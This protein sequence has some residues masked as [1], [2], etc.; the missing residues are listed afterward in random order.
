MG[1]ISSPSDRPTKLITIKLVNL[2][3]LSNLLQG[4]K[5]WRELSLTFDTPINLTIT[6][7]QSQVNL[8]LEVKATNNVTIDGLISG[9][10]SWL[11]QG[12]L[13]YSQLRLGIRVDI[14]HPS[15]L[16]GLEQW[17][18]LNLLSDIQVKQLCGQHLTSTL[19]PVATPKVSR[20]TRQQ[21]SK[22]KVKPRQRQRSLPKIAQMLQGLMAELSVIWLLLLGV[23]MVVISSGVLAASQWEKFPAIAQY[24]ILWVYTLGFGGASW[25]TSHKP[26]LR[27]TTQA[28]RVVTLS[29]VPINFVALDSFALWK[30]PLGWLVTG[31]AM[32]SL[33]TLTTQVFKS[34]NNSRHRFLSLFNHLGLSYIHLGWSFPFIPLG[35]T[36][37]GV[38]GTAVI[39]QLQK[40]QNRDQQPLS[41]QTSID[42]DKA[43]FPF[44]LTDAIISYALLILLIRAIFITQIDIFQL[45]LAVGICSW[46]MGWN[47]S[48]NS[49]L[50]QRVGGSGLFLG[51]LLSVIFTP[52]QAIAV[53]L[54]AIVWLTRNLGQSWQRK[55]LLL[56][57]TIGLQ[58]HWLLFRV[59][60]LGEITQWAI[61]ITETQGNGWALLSLGLFPY[62]TLIIVLIYWFLGLDKPKLAKL[63][64]NIALLLGTTLTIL[65]LVSPSLRTLNLAASTLTL[66]KLTQIQK[67]IAPSSET[68]LGT[69]THIGSLLT[70]ISWVN[71]LFPR[72]NVGI[73]ATIFL[74]LMALEGIFALS[75]PQS[76]SIL[77]LLWPS[78]WGLTLVL[79]G[80]SYG[81][82]WVNTPWVKLPEISPFWNFVWFL[83]PLT[84]TVIAIIAIK[85]NSSQEYHQ[86]EKPLNEKFLTITA[87]KTI[88]RQKLSGSLSVVALILMQGLTLGFPE[89][90][91]LGLISTTVLMV[92]NTFYLRHWL[93]ATLTVGFGLSVL[94]VILENFQLSL[95]QWLLSWAIATCLLWLLRHW[96]HHRNSQLLSLYGQVAD[97]W[98]YTLSSLTIVGLISY[99]LINASLSGIFPISALMMGGSVYRSWQP[100]LKRRRGASTVTQPK[101][102]GESNSF[103]LFSYWYSVLILLAVQ[104]PLWQVV[105]WRWLGLAIATG[106]MIFQTQQRKTLTAAVITIGFGLGLATICLWD[107]RLGFAVRSPSSWLLV[108]SVF[109]TTLWILRHWFLVTEKVTV[110]QTIRINYAKASDGWG[111]ILCSLLLWSLSFHSWAVYGEFISPSLEA[112]AASTLLLGTV[113]YRSW[114]RPTNWTI[115]GLGWSLE[116]L[117]IEIIALTGQS[118]IALAI[119]NIILGLLTQLLGEWWYRRT[120]KTQLLSSWHI[121]PLLYGGLGTALRW[122][123]FS[124]WTG[125]ISLGLVL[126]IIGVG[127]RTDRFQPL[128]YLAI[129]GLSLSA[130]ELLFYQVRTWPIGDQLLAMAALAT[131]I[132]YVYRFLSGWLTRYLHLSTKQLQTVAHFHW[133][134][135]SIFLITAVFY[136]VSFSQITGLG[137]GLFLTHYAI[138]QGR[139]HT[140]KLQAETW[141]YLGI[142]EG[143]GISFYAA[144]T[145]PTNT[146]FSTVLEIWIGSI[147]SLLSLVI[148]GLP[149]HQWGWPPRPWKVLAITLPLIGVGTTGNGI[150]LFVATICY[151]LLGKFWQRPRLFYLSLILGNWVIVYWFEKLNTPLFAY[152]CLLGG[153]IISVVWID[154][155]CQTIEGKRLRHYLRL[156][157]TGIIS[158]FS[159]FLYNKT[160]I[161]PA[162]LSMSLIFMGL[163]LQ[164]RA[165]LFVGT[166]TFLINA[167]YQLIILSLT[168]ALLKW[169]IGLI[170]GLM[171]IWIAASFENRRTQLSSLIRHW[172]TQLE[173]WD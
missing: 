32:L 164:I 82:L 160:G 109:T 56:I 122:N 77:R 135:G 148:A 158:F 63:T 153:S 4:L 10:Q 31:I 127:R 86:E 170:L 155:Y 59:L 13:S 85:N 166:I 99:S 147:I 53:S 140:H 149:W 131:S 156:L 12:L 14:N 8:N 132:M 27:L 42:K 7:N 133:F 163:S 61:Q 169:I 11:D 106:L 57:L 58:L 5:Q 165:F 43:K 129:A 24:G 111:F 19:T 41:P 80:L 134:L 68:W 112:I 100:F 93:S 89:T 108:T 36:Y 9:L 76:N 91:L 103:R 6:T 38:V 167:F 22:V 48:A 145:I 66:G 159:L 51:W 154:P 116:L 71:W 88:P 73:W 98:S 60:P 17:L 47:T 16:E 162:F 161:I 143:G 49:Q 1:K 55:D 30:T 168:Y 92:V 79:G 78:A 157:G 136:P 146:V 83:A 151:G 128:I 142:L 33:T 171:F 173:E 23:F 74:V 96:L 95:S 113:I 97:K 118:F 84:L 172:L 138:I 69:I 46:L 64:R 139:Y 141:I 18:H 115:Y 44:S 2:T 26:N 20:K 70:L 87:L 126:I 150:T 124:N 152:V 52:L 101:R 40:K 15:I 29:L 62:L 121:L 65:S 39:L 130:Y 102:G 72:L 110:N 104:I 50:W 117:T 125:L 94:G 37:L 114:Q 35:M 21:R 90:R 45:G 107:G 120:G 3:S 67:K 119:A 105:A 81:L 34:K 75:D 137:T 144:S 28:L 123:Y 54:L 25:W